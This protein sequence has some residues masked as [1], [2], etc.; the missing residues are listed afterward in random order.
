MKR[1]TFS[2]ILS[3]YSPFYVIKVRSSGQFLNYCSFKG[4]VSQKLRQRLLYIIQKL[5]FILLT[6]AI[7]SNFFARICV[8]FT[9]KIN[10]ALSTMPLKF[11]V[12]FEEY[13]FK[14][15]VSHISLETSEIQRHI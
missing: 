8:Q 14:F 12:S 7:K 15:S 1:S 11:S 3:S 6:H 2:K 10:G 5:F 13:L 9:F 4:T